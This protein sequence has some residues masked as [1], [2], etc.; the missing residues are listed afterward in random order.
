MKVRVSIIVSRAD[1]TMV[2][3]LTLSL[4]RSSRVESLAALRAISARGKHGHSWPIGECVQLAVCA[5]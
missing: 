4:A 1:G 5:E 3:S 2:S